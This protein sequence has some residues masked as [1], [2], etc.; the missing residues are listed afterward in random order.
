[1]KII[2]FVIVL[3]LGFTS[4]AWAAD[5]PKLSDFI[6]QPP[7]MKPIPDM[8]G[9]WHWNKPDADFKS[10]DKAL[11][12]YIEIFI[13]PDSEYKGIDADQ[14]KILADSMRAVMTDALE[15][16]T[17]VV[18]KAGPGVIILRIAITNVHLGKPKHQVG[19]Y[20]PIGLAVSGIKKLAG[21]S[22]NL[23]LK[24]ASVEAEMFDPQ[25]G[26]RVAVRIDTKP[27]RNMNDESEEMSWETI[28]ESLKVYGNRF[29][30]RAALF[31]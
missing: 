7:V 18:S 5:Q 24:D 25:T 22:R 12:T 26:E 19:Q 14:M 20:L 29:R 10:Y 2:P 30:D 23:S 21:K 15:P 13:A 31:R 11:L 9:A 16:D 27:L 6:E 28:E 8:P 4:Q 1:M 3:T 17:P